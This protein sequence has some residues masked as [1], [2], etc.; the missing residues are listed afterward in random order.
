MKKLLIGN[1]EELLEQNKNA[2]VLNFGSK[3]FNAPTFNLSEI[4]DLTE[5]AANLFTGLRTLDES[6]AKIIL[7]DYLPN[8]GLG[9]AINDRLTRAAAEK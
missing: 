2:C 9:M 5:A 6:A 4:S 3:K 8:I 7:T 1:I